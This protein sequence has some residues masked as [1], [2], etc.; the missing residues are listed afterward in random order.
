LT[1]LVCSIPCAP[2]LAD[3]GVSDSD[4]VFLSP[5]DI[6][7]PVPP[8]WEDLRRTHAVLVNHKS[9]LL[10][11]TIPLSY[12]DTSGRWDFLDELRLDSTVVTA[13][14]VWGVS[15]GPGGHDSLWTSREI[16]VDNTSRTILIRFATDVPIS[17]QTIDTL[18]ILH[19]LVPLESQPTA[20]G[21][22]MIDSSEV[23]GHHLQITGPADTLT[24]TWQGGQFTVGA[25]D[26][27]DPHPTPSFLRL[28]TL[29][30]NPFNSQVRVQFTLQAP[31][32][33]GLTVFSILGRRVRHWP[34]QRRSV[35]LHELV[36][37]GRDESGRTVASGVY[38]FVLETEKSRSTS[39]GVMLK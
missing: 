22:A 6:F 38:Y 12:N 39:A 14:G 10:T 16:E 34:T 27:V 18:C 23:S 15:F 17:P 3:Q 29:F 11:I 19:W 20:F 4:F 33:A 31:G 5:Y 35:G 24:P 7:E 30:P 1:V 9:P 37:D 13:P 28:I 36:W 26:N 25:I 2:C 21:F 8:F 32:Q